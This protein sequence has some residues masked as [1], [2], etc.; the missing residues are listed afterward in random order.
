MSPYLA[1]FIKSG[2]FSW[3]IGKKKND[4]DGKKLEPKANLINIWLVFTVTGYHN[5][6]IVTRMLTIKKKITKGRQPNRE[7]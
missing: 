3:T 6:T 5:V 4:T 2:Y 7:V 1:V